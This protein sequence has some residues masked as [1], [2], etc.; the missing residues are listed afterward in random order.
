MGSRLGKR[1]S[2][3]V[4]FVVP[5]LFRADSV[6]NLIKQGGEGYQR[7]AIGSTPQKSHG[8]REALVSSP[9]RTTIFP[10]PMP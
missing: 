10:S 7:S 2:K 9:G 3:G 5:P 8:K 6:T 1:A 4:C